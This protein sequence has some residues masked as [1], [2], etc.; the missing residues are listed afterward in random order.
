MLV[1]YRI[2]YK[3]WSICLLDSLTW[4][5]GSF[6]SNYFYSRLYF[7]IRECK[8]NL[9]WQSSKRTLV[10]FNLLNRLTWLMVICMNAIVQIRQRSL[11]T[12]QP[13]RCWQA[14]SLRW[15]VLPTPL[16]AREHAIPSAAGAN[17]ALS[18]DGQDGHSDRLSSRS[19]KWELE[20]SC[21]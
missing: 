8:E 4:A 12:R 3:K 19:R 21:F 14:Y 9:H 6:Y 7:W 2:V 1:W 11:G 16:P 13:G 17:S 5:V 20:G 18:V 15:R 10:K